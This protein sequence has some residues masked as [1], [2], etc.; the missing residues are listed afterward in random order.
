M[1]HQSFLQPGVGATLQGAFSLSL[2]LSLFFSLPSHV[3]SQFPNQGSILTL[4][5]WKHGV[6][7]TGLPG[8]V[9]TKGP[10]DNAQQGFFPAW[11]GRTISTTLHSTHACKVTYVMSDSATLWTVA[12]Q[13]PLSIGFSRQEYWSGL[14]FP[15]PGDLP[16]PGMEPKSPVS[17]ALAGGFFT[18]S[19][20]WEAEESIVVQNANPQDLPFFKFGKEFSE[21]SRAM[22]VGDGVK[23]KGLR[24]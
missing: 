8:K 6:L 24:N 5:H 16:D 4:L 19:A 3:G 14:L 17:P 7:A 9:P 22:Q 23:E 18:T 20:T 1:W 2:S 12:L 10:L 15:I 21:A 11:R 13:T